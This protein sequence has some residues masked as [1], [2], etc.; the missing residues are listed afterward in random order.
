MSRKLG[1]CHQNPILEQFSYFSAN[2]SYFWE[3]E[4]RVFPFFSPI[5]GRRPE[6]PILA[7]G[8][9]R[10]EGVR[11]GLFLEKN[12]TMQSTKKGFFLYVR[13]LWLP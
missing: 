4:I 10:K 13:T 12:S 5:L 9:G 11:K 7:G 1:T 8:Q 6:I 3:A 2:F